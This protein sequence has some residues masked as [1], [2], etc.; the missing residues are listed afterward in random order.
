VKKLKLLDPN[1]EPLVDAEIAGQYLGYAAVTVRKHA[2]ENRIPSV[3]VPCG[4]R[5]TWRFR[6]SELQAMN[7]GQLRESLSDA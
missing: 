1:I 7:N 3:P 2:R 6:I 5:T 4:A